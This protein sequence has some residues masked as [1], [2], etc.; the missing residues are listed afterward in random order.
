MLFLALS[1]HS[2]GSRS[3]MENG[4]TVSGESEEISLFFTFNL[5]LFILSSSYLPLDLGVL[6][7]FPASSLD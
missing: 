1:L 2:D 4:E 5:E 7:D 3:V 6:F